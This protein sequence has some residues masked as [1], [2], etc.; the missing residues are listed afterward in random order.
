MGLNDTI[1]YCSQHQLIVN[2]GAYRN[3]INYIRDEV[4][5]SLSEIVY[6]EK[7]RFWMGFQAKIYI[8]ETQLSRIYRRFGQFFFL[9]FTVWTEKNIRL[10]VM[11]RVQN[12]QRKK[13]VNSSSPT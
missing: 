4:R 2:S 12:D 8:R 11:S 7:E 10:V 13:C 5:Q 1:A 9:I 6:E 3:W